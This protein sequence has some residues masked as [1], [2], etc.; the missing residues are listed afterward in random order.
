MLHYNPQHVSSSNLLI[1]RRANCTITASGIVT[2]FKEPY[3]I[4]VESLFGTFDGN[5]LWIEILYWCLDFFFT[6]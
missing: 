5:S 6:N 1:F 4:P 3:S 2:F